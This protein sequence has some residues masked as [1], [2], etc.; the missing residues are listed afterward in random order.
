MEQPS[1][2][3]L[4]DSVEIKMIYGKKRCLAGQ[5]FLLP[6]GGFHLEVKINKDIREYNEA[7]FF[8]MSM[9]Q[10]VGA[11][12]AVLAAVGAYFGLHSRMG[13]ETVSWLCILAA[14]PFAALGFVRYHGMTC[15]QA[16]WV[17][18]RSELLEPR[19][20]TASQTNNLH[21]NDMQNLLAEKQA[22]SLGKTS[23]QLWVERLQGRFRK[24]KEV[25]RKDENPG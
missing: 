23:T 7:V 10:C 13:T 20:L 9:R 11:G 8:G 21:G 17:W 6:K 24:Q 16:L 1:G 14:A 4:A 5:R 19:R 3:R 18:L 12:L 25:I 2:L 22:D 15:E